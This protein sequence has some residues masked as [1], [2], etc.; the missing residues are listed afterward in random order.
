MMAIAVPV[1]ARGQQKEVN[2]LLAADRAYSAAAAKADLISGLTAMFADDVEMINGPTRAHVRGKENVIAALQAVPA[3]AHA[4]AT[5]AP[6]RA[7]ISADGQQ[8]FTFGYMTLRDAAGVETPLKYLAYWV[9]QP[10]GWKVA[11]YKRSRR[12]AGDVSTEMMSPSVPAKM[13]P[14]VSDAGVIDR[15]RQSL[16]AAE[17]AFSDESAVIGLGPAFAKF[18]RDDAMNM[19]SKP[20]FTIGAKAISESVETPPIMIPS[21]LTWKSD[22][23]IVAST[24]DL[25][26]SIGTIRRRED[27]SVSIP[28]FTVWRR[29]ADGRWRYIAE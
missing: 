10:A 6:I 15:H 3:N 21:P 4:S 23:V 25:G 17:Q 26:V 22:W 29:D 5:W 1:V 2:E 18:G 20:D 7:G 16:A 11:A 28:F 9:K 12:P 14:P 24:G 19:G 8:G 27:P 13:G